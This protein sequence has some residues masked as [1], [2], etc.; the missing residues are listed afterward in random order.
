MKVARAAIVGLVILMLV[1]GIVWRLSRLEI[2]EVGATQEQASPTPPGVIIPVSPSRPALRY[3]LP[4]EI[5]KIPPHPDAVSFGQGKAEEEPAKL[6]NLFEVFRRELGAFPSGEDN[7]QM[8]N[9]LCGMNPGMLAIFPRDHPRLDPEAG[10]LD[11]WG[12]PFVFHL[13]S[14]EYLEIRSIGR[15]GEIFSADDIVVPGPRNP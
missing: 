5:Q 8:M 11:A 4:E 13:I 2:G 6:L 10:L 12:R 1:A 3:P 14:H 15:D 7:R 9:A